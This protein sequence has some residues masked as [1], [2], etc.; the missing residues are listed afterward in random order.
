MAAFDAPDSLNALELPIRVASEVGPGQI[1]LVGAGEY[2][3]AMRPVDAQL[4]TLTPAAREGRT[5]RVICLPTAAGTEGQR[6]VSRWMRMGIDHFTALGADAVALP[7]VDH[8]TAADA[9]HE[10]TLAAADLVY[11]SGG[12]PPH[13]LDSLR[14]TSTWRGILTMLER[15]GVLAGCS[16]GAMIMGSHVPGLALTTT[17][18]AGFG[19]VPG[20]MVMPHFDELFG[21]FAALATLRAPPGSYLL[22][23]D[24]GTGLII[25]ADGWRVLGVGRVVVDDGGAR[26]ELRAAARG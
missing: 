17:M 10:A 5:P 7:I 21:R 12:K 19:L 23:I 3:P 22:G 9:G 1:C 13:L 6:V 16:A 20:A 4:L 24:G 15:G 14:D 2:L 18:R 11:L 25:G 8:R 26:R